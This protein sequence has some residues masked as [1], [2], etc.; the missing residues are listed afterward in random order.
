M[1]HRTFKVWLAVLLVTFVA[2]CM[3]PKDRRPG[4]RLSGDVVSE[5][6]TDWSFSNEFE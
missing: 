4:T 5:A 6:I 3:E 1:K 2:G